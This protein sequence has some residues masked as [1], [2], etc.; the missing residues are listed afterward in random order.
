MGVWEV[1]KIPIKSFTD[2]TRDVIEIFPSKGILTLLLTVGNIV[3]KEK[4][5]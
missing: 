4:K 5:N 2:G 3:E 1:L